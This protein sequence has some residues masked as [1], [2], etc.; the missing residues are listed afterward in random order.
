MIRVI[1]AIIGIVM[2][3]VWLGSPFTRRTKRFISVI[4]MVCAGVMIGVEVHNNKPRESLV[5]IEQV[6]VCGLN[7]NATYR[8]D[9]KVALCLRNNSNHQIKRIRFAVTAQTCNGPDC[10]PL[11]TTERDIPIN[12]SSGEEQLTEQ[13]LRFANVASDNKELQWSASIVSVQAIP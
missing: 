5:S 13:T 6:S 3:W 2:L 4:A 7:V 1:I 11:E 10:E 12:I 9:Y 8:S